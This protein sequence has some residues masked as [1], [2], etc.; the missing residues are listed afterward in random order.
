MDLAQDSHKS[1][2]LGC[3]LNCMEAKGTEESGQL[4]LR[5]G[6]MGCQ[7]ASKIYKVCYEGKA[8]L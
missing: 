7:G 5:H 4:S 2:R 8:K 3:S 6:L 1:R